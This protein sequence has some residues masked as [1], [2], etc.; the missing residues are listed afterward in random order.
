MKDVLAVGV[1][2]NVPKAYSNIQYD[3]THL[4]ISD[5]PLESWLYVHVM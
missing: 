3:L 2:V 4:L 1:E 5:E